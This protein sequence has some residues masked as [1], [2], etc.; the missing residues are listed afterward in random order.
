MAHVLGSVKK[1]IAS[2]NRAVLLETGLGLDNTTERTINKFQAAVRTWKHKPTFLKKRAA[3]KTGLR[4]LIELG[5][6]AE[7]IKIFIYVDRG[8]KPHIIAPKNSTVLV[9]NVGYSA[10]TSPVANSNAGSGV[11]TGGKV[12]TPNPVQHP[13]TEARAFSGFF[14]LEAQE[15][16]DHEIVLAIQRVN[17][18]R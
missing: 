15:Q 7:N 12:V 18:K 11:A 8:T 6:S 10:K 13:G 17:R 1:S 3:S 9:F 5:G 4:Q 2:L 16:L 14:A